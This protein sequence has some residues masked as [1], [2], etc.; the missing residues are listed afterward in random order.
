MQ[1]L[2]NAP[3]HRY[4]SPRHPPGAPSCCPE[5]TTVPTF[6]TLPRFTADL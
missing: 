4:S 2:R 1:I 3:R 5:E 6:E